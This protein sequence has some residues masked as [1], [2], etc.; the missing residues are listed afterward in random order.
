MIEC[1]QSNNEQIK[2]RACETTLRSLG[3]NDG[4]CNNDNNTIINQ[5]INIKDRETEIKNIF[6]IEE[7]NNE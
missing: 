5:Q 3:K 7:E 1:L 2:L 4:W 6:G